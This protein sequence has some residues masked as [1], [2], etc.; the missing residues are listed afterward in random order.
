MLEYED[1]V[2]PPPEA[3]ARGAALGRS[4]AAADV[5]WLRTVQLIGDP[6]AERLRWPSLEEWVDLT[7]R[8]DPTFVAPYFFGAAMLVGDTER[9]RN[10]DQILRRGQEAMPVSFSFPMMRGFI[11]YFALLDPAAAATHYREAAGLPG[12]P[13][14]LEA[15][16]S[17][18]ETQVHT[19][20]QMLKDL[21]AL[22]AEEGVDRRR[23]MLAERE[24]IL[25]ACV[26]G[27]LKNAAGAYRNAHGRNGSLAELREAGLVTG[28]LFAP[29][30]RCWVVN[31]GR[32]ALVPCP[33]EAR[34]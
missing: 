20:G 2:G 29:K 26:E 7:T 27:Q 4:Y 31:G 3:M 28:E 21:N 5:A 9:A 23:A 16:A 12:A 13:R 34:P 30:G 15:F 8:L 17:R 19:C 25:V 18:L 24:P 6:V 14:Y 33:A 22:A 1:T 32:P 10:V 11:A